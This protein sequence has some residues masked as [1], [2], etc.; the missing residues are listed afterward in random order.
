MK[1]GVGDVMVGGGYDGVT[2]PPST[3]NVRQN[4]LRGKLIREPSQLYVY[5]AK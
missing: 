4:G 3:D 1:R 5:V 2:L